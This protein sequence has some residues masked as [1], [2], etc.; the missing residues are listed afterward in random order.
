MM[1]PQGNTKAM[2]CK[3]LYKIFN[4]KEPTIT[5]QKDPIEVNALCFAGKYHCYGIASQVNHMFY[6][7]STWP[8][9]KGH[10]YAPLPNKLMRSRECFHC[11]KKGHYA[12]NCQVR[13]WVNHSW[14]EVAEVCS[15]QTHP[16][17]GI[18]PMN[19]LTKR[20]QENKSANSFNTL[21]EK[22]LDHTPE[23]LDAKK[24]KKLITNNK[25]PAHTLGPQKIKAIQEFITANAH[26]FDKATCQELIKLCKP[27]TKPT[28]K[29]MEDMLK[30]Q[31][32]DMD[33]DTKIRTLNMLIPETGFNIQKIKTLA[34]TF[35]LDSVFVNKSNSIQIK[36]ALVSYKRE[37]MEV[38]LPDTRATESFIDQE[39]VNQLCLGQ[40]ELPYK[41]AVFNIDRT[42]NRN[43]TIS[44]YC[45][46]MVSKGNFRWQTCFYVTN[47]G[48]DHFIFGYPWCK[49]FNV[50]I[51]WEN[52]VL[53]GPKVKVETIWKITWDKEQG[54]L[55]EKQ[56]QQQDNDLIMDIYKAIIEELEDQTNIWIGRTT[57]E[58][59][60]TYNAMEMVHKYTKLHKK[61]EVTLPAEFKQHAT[62]FLD[63]EA[64]KF[65]PSWPC[66][67]KI[68]LTAE[69]PDK[70]NCK[71]YPMSLKDQEAENKFLDKNLKKGYI[72]L[73]ESPYV[74][75]ALGDCDYSHS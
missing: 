19:Q 22:T 15:I 6:K 1:Q 32:K 36:F 63:E 45:N 8:Q 43:G 14:Q 60:R 7:N 67:H 21:K 54:Y 66:D 56:K 72:V 44:H 39:T 62:L 24:L 27:K 30:E 33:E 38:T 18:L 12:C 74:W 58:I 65:L 26:K 46:L 50:N 23:L 48:K 52:S 69:A 29:Q 11:H 40:K 51:N 75:L 70:F 64:K 53:K 17:M 59:N 71:T 10:K 35:G 57:M 73:S 5:E 68:E 2:L 13:C 41:W 42:A 34:K 55:K 25:P 37:T 4:I 61:E 47:L 16:D 20:V 49:E 9:D 31:I 3:A 28:A